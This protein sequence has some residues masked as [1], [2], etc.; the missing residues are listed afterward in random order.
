MAQATSQVKEAFETNFP[1]TIT[2]ELAKSIIRYVEYYETRGTHASAFNTYTLGIHPC[3][4][5]K[6]DAEGYFELFNTDGKSIT[7]YDVKN[8]ILKNTKGNKVFGIDVNKIPK[9]DYSNIVSTTDIRRTVKNLDAINSNFRVMSDPFNLFIPYVLYKLQ[10]ADIK[11]NIKYL[12]QFKSIMLLQYK[13]FTSLVNYRF[14]YKPDEAVMQAMYENLSNKFDLKV[15][16]TWRRVFEIRAEQLLSPN[17]LHRSVIDGFD[18][19][20]DIT[21]FITDLNNRVR[22]Q[23]NNITSKFHEAKAN[24]D[25]IEEYGTI[26]TD[27]EGEKVVLGTLS[28]YDAM[29][30]NIYNDSLNINKFLDD[31]YIRLI[32]GSGGTNV[33]LFSNLNHTAFKN[34]LISFSEYAVMQTKAG[35]QNLTRKINGVELLLGPEILIHT[36]IQKSYRFCVQS[37]VDINNK[38]AILRAVKDVFSSSRIADEGILQIRNSMAKLVIDLQSSRREVVMSALR[39]AFVV[40]IILLSFKY[41]GTD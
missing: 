8:F 13:F 7:E 23:V 12:A 9:S 34:F 33:G 3:V 5:T 10:Q 14:P 36:I 6:N 22:S 38:Q 32:S 18:V 11:L 25:R 2:E 41:L 24:N 35:K 28:A 39:I 20:K 19:D 17:S 37:N 16:G 27:K 1:I 4:F 40:Y 26:G 29:A 31:R 30:T 21:Y 15:Y